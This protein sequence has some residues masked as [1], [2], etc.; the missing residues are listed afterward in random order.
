MNKFAWRQWQTETL[1]IVSNVCID[2]VWKHE[3]DEELALRKL[4][5]TPEQFIYSPQDCIRAH[6][7]GVSL[8]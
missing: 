7:M 3:I 4:V 1:E 6:S 8:S 5:H 2:P